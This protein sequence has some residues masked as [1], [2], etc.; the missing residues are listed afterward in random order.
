[1]TGDATGGAD[2]PFPPQPEAS[3]EMAA[4]STIAANAETPRE[5]RPNHNL[6]AFA[7]VFMILISFQR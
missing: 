7:F 4:K 6:L 2:V 3:T 1:M 5:L